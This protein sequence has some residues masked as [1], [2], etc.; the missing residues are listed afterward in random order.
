[1][2]QI[3]ISINLALEIIKSQASSLKLP[4]TYFSHNKKDGKCFS[5]NKG[6]SYQN[7]RL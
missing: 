7:W 2:L 3:N 1:M 5:I 6:A 4:N